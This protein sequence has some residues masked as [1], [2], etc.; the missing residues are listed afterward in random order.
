MTAPVQKFR[1]DKE[2]HLCVTTV[3]HWPSPRDMIVRK[4]QAET[5]SENFV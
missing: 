5:L 3:S 4:A 2:L 1:F